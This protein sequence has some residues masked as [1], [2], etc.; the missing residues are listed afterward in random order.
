MPTL[1]VGALRENFRRALKRGDLED[2]QDIL[3]RLKQEDPLSQETR[4]FEL[5]LSLESNRLP[6][7]RTLARQLCRLFPESG[8]MAFLAGKVAYRLRDY[9]EAESY[10]RESHRIYPHWRNSYWLGKTLTQAGHFEEAESLLM[11]AREQ[12]AHALLDLAWLYQ[13]KKD[14]QAAL[15]A[16]EEFLTIYPEHEFALEQRVRIKGLM[17]DPDSLI[18]ELNTLTGLGEDIPTLLFPEY[19]QKLFETGQTLAARDQITAKLNAL[20][21]KTLSRVAWVCYRAAAYDLACT[22]FL[23]NLQANLP[24]YK[25]L[26]ALESAAAK[27]GRLPQIIE[28]YRPYTAEIPNLHGR[29]RSMTSRLK[30]AEKSPAPESLRSE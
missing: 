15:K 27:C 28:A 2:A 7:A 11:T 12:T 19:L 30:R 6:E 18:E 14:Y 23:K 10:F 20:N 21:V 25:Y 4:G 17:L 13:R 26:N 1:V 9:K 29:V 8:R 22:L 24:S 5:E 16:C 3:M